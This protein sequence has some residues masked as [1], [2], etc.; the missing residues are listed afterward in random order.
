MNFQY[1]KHT[2]II[3]MAALLAGAVSGCTP[4]SSDKELGPVPT[5]SFT[6]EPLADN[7]NKIVV[8]NTTPGGFLFEWKDDNGNESKREKDTLAY[9]AAGEYLLKFTVFTNG[10]YDTA[11]KKITIAQNARTQDILKGGNMEAGSEQFWTVLN[12]GGTQTAIKFENG[13][14]NFSNTGNSN[15]AIYQEVNVKAGKFY[16]FSGLVSGDGATDSWF[17]VVFGTTAPVQGSDYSGTKFNSLNTWS[18]CGK[19]PFRDKD[20][21]FFGCDGSGVG[22]KGIM[23]FNT[24][25]K[26][27][28]VIKAGS[29]NGGNLGNG[30][31]S[32]DD[33]KFQ[34]E[35]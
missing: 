17:E 1:I 7:P 18:G 34:E 25:G 22:K 5:A 11:V 30:G 33:V 20:L 19:V 35:I 15:G 23:K 8:S 12:T 14:L 9:F 24:S 31:I 32:I 16:V 28:L 27:Y 10:G 29:A 26:V 6:A 2:R 13:K 21:A 4:E 3:A